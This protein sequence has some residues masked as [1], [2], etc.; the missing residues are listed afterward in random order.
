MSIVFSTSTALQPTRNPLRLA[1]L[2]LGATEP[3][4]ISPLNYERRQGT[5]VCAGCTRPLFDAST[6]FDSGTGWPS[7]WNP[8]SPASVAEKVE[9][10]VGLEALLGSRTECLCSECNGHL[11]HVFSDGPTLDPQGTGKEATG[12]RYCVNGASLRFIPAVV[13]L[14]S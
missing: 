5:Y 7:F 11:G 1:V 3:A 2:K 13:S 8:I 6:K 4:W 9:A 12:L 14:E 10:A